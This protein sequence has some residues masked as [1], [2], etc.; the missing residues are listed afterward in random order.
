MGSSWERVP[1]RCGALGRLGDDVVARCL[2]GADADVGIVRPGRGPRQRTEGADAEQ[3]DVGRD[4]RSG[5][6]EVRIVSRLTLQD[7]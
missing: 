7:P 3:R 4:E 6:S 1:V 5:I 2:R